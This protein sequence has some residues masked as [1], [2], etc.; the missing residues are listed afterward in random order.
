MDPW[1]IGPVVDIRQ[2][3]VV[4]GEPDERVPGN[5]LQGLVNDHLGT[6]TFELFRHSVSA[7]YRV[8]VVTGWNE[9]SRSKIVE[10]I[11]TQQHGLRI[12]HL[13]D[14]PFTLNAQERPG[15]PRDGSGYAGFTA[16]R[17]SHWDRNV[18]DRV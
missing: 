3:T 1:K 17:A 15:P 6:V 8:Q 10:Y 9:L 7:Q 13:R 18:G 16:D 11:L 2:A 12:G 14:Q 4:A 5:E